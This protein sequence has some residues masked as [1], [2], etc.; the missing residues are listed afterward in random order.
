MAQETELDVAN[1]IDYNKYHAMM[2]TT[3]FACLDQT[4]IRNSTNKI[5]TSILSTNKCKSQTAPWIFFTCGAFGSG[6]T[7]SLLFLDS[8]NFFILSDYL[9][10]DPDNIKPKLSPS[11]QYQHRESAYIALILEYIALDR[12]LSIIVDGSMRN[13]EWNLSHLDYIRKN[14]PHY[15]IGLIH[16][17][18]KLET[19]IE[20]C[21]IRALITGRIIPDHEI[22]K[23]HTKVMESFPLYKRKVDLCI[24]LNNDT[25]I[26]VKEI[27]Y[28]KTN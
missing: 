25:N 22:I 24:T 26:C 8:H 20:R 4:E 13:K 17:S 10:I 18:T 5:V 11:N 15:Q 16:I 9:I 2:D 6:K 1:S 28:H 7:S 3:Y 19:I 14:Y 23:S 12:N 27:E 21:H